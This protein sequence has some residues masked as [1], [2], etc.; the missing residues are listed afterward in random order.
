MGLAWA[1]SVHETPLTKVL[2]GS[3]NSCGTASGSSRDSLEVATSW[4]YFLIV[5]GCSS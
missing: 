4:P 1:S 2:G 5:S 3:G